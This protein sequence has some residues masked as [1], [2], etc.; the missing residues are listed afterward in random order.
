M[1]QKYLLF[2]ILV[3][4]IYSCKKED[5]E[6]LNVVTPTEQISNNYF[7]MTIGSYWV[8]EF[9]MHLANGTIVDN[10]IIDTIMVIGDTLISGESYFVFETNKPSSNIIYYRRINEIGEVVSQN[11]QLICPPDNS[12]SNIY[13]S[14]YGFSGL[15]TTYHY[16]EEFSGLTEVNNVLVDSYE[17][18]QMTAYHQAWPSFGS[19]LIADTNFFSSVGMLQRSYGFLSGSKQ[20]GTLVDYHIE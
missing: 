16:W 6:T 2:A 8:Y 14:H 12:Y 15:D 10:N 5:V 17:C 7:P 13:N 19:A 9:D 4:G 18:I 11:N 3:T 1:S 20:V